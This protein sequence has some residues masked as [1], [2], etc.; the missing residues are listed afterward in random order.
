MSS[1]LQDV[2]D[3]SVCTIPTPPPT[4][5]ERR[6]KNRPSV[7]LYRPPGL[8]SSDENKQAKPSSAAGLKQPKRD[9]NELT[10]ENNNE[11]TI[12][13]ERTENSSSPL[14]NSPTSSPNGNSRGVLKRNDSSVS[15]SSQRSHH[16]A[17][18]PAMFVKNNSSSGPKGS[19]KKEQT[20]LRPANQQKKK[21]FGSKEVG[22]IA[23]GFKQLSFSKEAGNIEN[24]L[25]G[26]E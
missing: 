18:P 24:F 8:R 20:P 16:R 6:S 4:N 1:S 25:N 12:S 11:K 17:S 26:K 3:S 7:Q 10:E 21:Q 23:V 9:P 2:D 5:G 22:E 15:N 19:H 14:S 13:A